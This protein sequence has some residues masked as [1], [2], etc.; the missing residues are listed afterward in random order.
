MILD[1]LCTIKLVLST[2]WQALVSINEAKYSLN[3]YLIRQV[4]QRELPF[5]DHC[6]PEFKFGVI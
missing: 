5:V 4:L 3:K 2:F 1:Q 6:Y